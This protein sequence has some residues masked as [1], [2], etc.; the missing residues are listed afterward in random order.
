MNER[1]RCGSPNAF[2]MWPGGLLSGSFDWCWPDVQTFELNDS[3]N[4]L[5]SF[6]NF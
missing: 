1:V 3:E 4:N 5:A 2:E 6:V